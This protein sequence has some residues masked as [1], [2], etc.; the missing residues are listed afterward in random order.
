MSVVGTLAVKITGDNSGLDKSLKKSNADIS[1]FAKKSA[2]ALVAAAGTFATFT[3]KT[4]DSF[5]R[6]AK[7]S[8]QAGVTTESLSALGYAAEL[9][10]V[11]TNTLATNLGRL[12]KGMLDAA[13]GTGEAK[14]AFDTLGIDGGTLKD[15]DEALMQIADKFQQLP[16]GAQKTALA[17]QLFGRSGMQMIPFLN[18]GRDGLE[19]IRQE[20]ERF[21]I[22]VSTDASKAAEQFNDNLS[23]IGAVSKGFFYS[24]ANLILPP[25][26]SYIDAVFEAERATGSWFRS[27]AI[28][29]M[30]GLPATF[31]EFTTE[32]IKLET[33]IANTKK[34]LQDLKDG[35]P[36]DLFGEPMRDLGMLE[37]RLKMLK[38]VAEIEQKRRSQL[39]N[40]SAPNFTM[41]SMPDFSEKTKD[42]LDKS[43]KEYRDYLTNINESTKKEISDAEQQISEFAVSAARNIQGVLGDG[44]FNMLSGKFDDIGQSFLNML[45]RMVAD[46]LSSQMA[47]LL[48]GNFGTTNQIGGIVGQ[49]A[50]AIGTAIGGGF[51]S[52]PGLAGATMGG[53][54]TTARSV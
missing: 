21:G 2:L 12:S 5:D 28:A 9:S 31:D 30:G 34:S 39:T 7:L 11:N 37:D 51:S 20:A 54:G 42:D 46:L 45:N 16:D 49:I 4:I 17:I 53:T 35:A 32:I 26:N 47:Q 33:E 13:N 3:K 18:Q 22:V 29:Q 24:V 50:G 27:M 6:L 48:F 40:V 19:Q 36:V 8:V 52:Q 1:A 14:K 44:I 10:G 43:E 41:P 15:A 25:I 23:R 38:A